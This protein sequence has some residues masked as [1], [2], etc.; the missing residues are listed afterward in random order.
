M[1]Y[2]G[3]EPKF[4]QKDND[5]GPVSE[6]DLEIDRLLH[7]ELLAARPD[8]GWLSEETDED[9]GRLEQDRIFIVDPIDGTRSFLAREENFAVAMAVVEKGEVTAALV[10]MP[11]KGRTYSAAKGKGAFLNGKPIQPSDRTRVKNAKVLA[12]GPQLLSQLWPNG[13]PPIKRH[14]RSSLAYRMC[15]VA[16]GRFDAM[17]T[18]RPSW[19]WDCSAGSLICEEAGAVVTNISNARHSFNSKGAKMN[20]VIAAPSK[21]HKGLMSYR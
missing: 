19:E 21:L 1:H 2:F 10:H 12:A 4:W 20:G 16:E 11:A 5:Q 6:A 18:L 7:Q 15:L 17:L 14:F 3:Y 8:Y 13:A 9:L